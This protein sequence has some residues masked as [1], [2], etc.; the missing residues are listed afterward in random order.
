MPI[1]LIRSCRMDTGVESEDGQS[2]AAKRKRKLIDMEPYEHPQHL[3]ARVYFEADGRTPVA[4]GKFSV[5]QNFITP[6]IAQAANMDTRTEA[7][8]YQVR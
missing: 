6:R 3:I 4:S 7:T 1:F 2:F 5:D 8:T